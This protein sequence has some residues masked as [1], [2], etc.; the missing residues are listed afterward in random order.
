MDL[1]SIETTGGLRHL[2]SFVLEDLTLVD[3][4]LSPQ[5]GYL[6]GANLDSLVVFK[7]DPETSKLTL[8]KIVHD[9]NYLHA[10][11]ISDDGRYLFSMERNNGPHT[12]R[13]FDLSNPEG[14][15][16]IASYYDS[17][18]SFPIARG[19]CKTADFRNGRYAIEFFCDSSY[20]AMEYRPETGSF[21]F[22]GGEVA[23][24]RTRYDNMWPIRTV[25]VA[26]ESSLDGGH[27]YMASGN[28]ERPGIFVFERV[29]NTIEVPEE[30]DETT[31]FRLDPFEVGFDTVQ[32][33]VF[34]AS[35]GD[36]V[37]FRKATF[38]NVSYSIVRSW[39]QERGNE[40]APWVDI[41][42]MEAEGRLCSYRPAD[43][44]EYRLAADI[45]V[46]SITGRYAS[47]ILDL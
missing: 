12:I 38:D 35:G 39:W 28:P 2:E 6:Y 41:A 37:S 21:E 32:F 42:G 43:G 18:N 47:N 9:S 8:A 33:G 7:R 25:P 10:I 30:V 3:V 22:A 36:C 17:T 34:H 13:V 11:S 26:L 24:Y 29:G 20:L 19:Q 46:N 23:G 44:A 14:P 4:A 45:T 31:R 27:I 16:E 40:D 15:V 5:N 1:L